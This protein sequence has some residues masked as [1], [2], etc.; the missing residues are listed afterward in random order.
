[1]SLDEERR[2]NSG[3]SELESEPE[4]ERPRQ[5]PA[6]LPRTL[7]DRQNFTTYNQETEYYDAWQGVP[8]DFM[9]RRPESVG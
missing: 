2:P 3:H 6:D 9:R 8:Q 4:D 1:M 5:L 7:D